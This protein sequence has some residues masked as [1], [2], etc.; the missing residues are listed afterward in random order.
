MGWHVK[1]EKAMTIT[2]GDY[3]NL[4]RTQSGLSLRDVASLIGVSHVTIGD[5][6]HNVLPVSIDR[7]LTLERIIPGFLADEFNE[8]Q[9]RFRHVVIETQDRS[10]QFRRLIVKLSRRGVEQSVSDTIISVMISL[11]E[12]QPR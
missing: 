3:L 12:N 10:E 2:P 7:S 8:L 6:E 11:L 1:E 4:K 5:Y 9:S